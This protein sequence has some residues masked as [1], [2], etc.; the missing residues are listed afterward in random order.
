MT[1]LAPRPVDDSAARAAGPV[2]LRLDPAP[3]AMVWTQPGRPHDAVAVPG[4]RLAPGDLLVEIELATICGSDVHTTRGDRA[5]PVPLVLGHE[6]V[7]RIVAVGQG[8]VA[9][10]GTPLAPGRR[11]VW[12]LTASCGRCATCARGLPQ[13]CERVRKYGHE[14]LETGWELSGGFATHVH[15]RAGTSVVPVADDLDARLLAPVSCGTATAV[16]ALDAASAI[17]P[18]DGRVAGS[19][20]ASRAA[21]AA[22]AA[23]ASGSSGSV[24]S[25]GAS[26]APGPSGSA[27]PDGAAA[28]PAAPVVVLVLGAGLIGL[29]VAALATDAG[30]RVV[31]VD[32]DPG[33]RALAVRFGAVATGDPGV[34]ADADG[35]VDRALEAAGGAPLVAVEASGSP[36]AVAS[37]LTRLG[38]GG[39]AVLVGSVSPAPA[40]PV[41]AESVVRRLVTVRGVHNYAPRHLVEAARFVE[42]RHLAWPLADLVGDEVPLTDLDTGLGRAASAGAVRVAVRP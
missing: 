33:R 26:G 16:A 32:P 13:K 17:M 3:T 39:V 20:G 30:A 6:Q 40:V 2:E 41:D 22:G 36:H 28:A 8:A 27:S 12:S 23:G 5:A 9:V 38:V 14:R 25:A 24:G 31:V 19:S 29:T 4:V 10:D 34:A 18:L 15:V 21:G 42:R 37:A 11:V 7:G 35:S 1:A